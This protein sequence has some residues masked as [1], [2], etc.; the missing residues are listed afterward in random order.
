MRGERGACGREE[1]C[2]YFL[3]GKPEGKEINWKTVTN[4]RVIL[5]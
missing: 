3:V 2:I 4:G 5:K 1:K